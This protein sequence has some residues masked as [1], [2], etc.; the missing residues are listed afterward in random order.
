MHYPIRFYDVLSALAA[1]AELG[2]AKDQRCQD[3][4]DLLES[5]GLADGM[6]PVEWTNVRRAN[7]I[8]TR[9][10]YADWGPIHKRKGNPLV[11]I[12]TLYVLREAGRG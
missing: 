7:E 11:T 12:D 4:I 5:K 3:A 1:I 6:L 8:E 9:G 10:T 2:L